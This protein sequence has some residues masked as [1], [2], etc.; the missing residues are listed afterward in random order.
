MLPE[1]YKELCW[2]QKAMTRHRGIQDEEELMM[3]IL[4]YV[5]GHSLVEVTHYAKVEFGTAISDVGFMKRFNRCNEWVK[6]IL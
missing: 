6:S 1:N 2:K 4:F 5:C 3:L